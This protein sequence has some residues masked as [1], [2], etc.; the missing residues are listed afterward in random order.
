MKIKNDF[1]EGDIVL[2]EECDFFYG[3]DK[4]TRLGKVTKVTASRVY[5]ER[6]QNT[7][8]FIAGGLNITFG[9]V[10]TRLMKTTTYM[11]TSYTLYSSQE[12]YDD[13]KRE[14]KAD[15]IKVTKMRIDKEL[16]K[17][18]SKISDEN[19]RTLFKAATDLR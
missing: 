14:E 7:D 9:K 17:D 4:E 11:M 6:S 5:V 8:E 13:V 18:P 15:K 3:K 2:L 19:L 10:K 16:S 1:K 12:Q